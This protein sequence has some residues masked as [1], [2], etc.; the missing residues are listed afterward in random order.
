MSSMSLAV[1]LF[2]ELNT[3]KIEKHTTVLQCRLFLT[4]LHADLQLGVIYVQYTIIINSIIGLKAGQPHI[5]RR[6]LMKS[7]NEGWGGVG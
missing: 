1:S 6:S 2:H 3:T 5:N 7:L 4:Y